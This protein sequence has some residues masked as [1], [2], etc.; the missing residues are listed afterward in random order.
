MA[1]SNKL[2]RVRMGE[3][4]MEAIA[5]YSRRCLISGGKGSLVQMERYSVLI[6]A[7]V[8]SAYRTCLVDFHPLC[9]RECAQHT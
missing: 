6:R 5:G 3:G 2:L 8:L 4:K 9:V 7:W 1:L